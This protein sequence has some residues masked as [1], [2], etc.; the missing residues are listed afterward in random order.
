MY[1][2]WLIIVGL[3][4]ISLLTA[5]SSNESTESN[6]AISDDSNAA[7]DG[8]T[9]ESYDRV[10]M[11]DDAPDRDQSRSNQI[12][13]TESE[14]Q[15]T[16]QERK[17]IYTANL[18]IEVED[19]TQAVQ[20]I[21]SQV[22]DNN[23]Y[24]VEST[25]YGGADDDRQEG[26]LKVR[27]PQ[28]HFDAFIQVIEEGSMKVMEKNVSGQDVTEEFV[29]LE[30][31]LQSKQ[32]VEERLLTFM[33]QAEETEDLLQISNDL[34]DVQEE[35]E[36][37][38][39]RLQYL[40]NKTDLATVTI[41]LHENRV[42]IPNVHD[43]DLNTWEKT[44]QQFMNSINFLLSAGSALVVF[45]VGNLPTILLLGIIGLIVYSI[46]KKQKQRQKE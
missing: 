2:R 36:Q 5:C 16:D 15:A 10:S 3:C 18:Q 12:E 9:E 40:Q 31:R 20:D 43:E 28:Q 46:Y 4:I 6:E 11:T 37:I 14:Q 25:T 17:V 34:A 22:T 41:H 26:M 45:I 21:Q 35:I 24:V 38:T 44:K 33:E 27:I 1:K 29:D 13:S 30:S 19:Y 42:N 8:A 32:V 7:A 23:G 39:G